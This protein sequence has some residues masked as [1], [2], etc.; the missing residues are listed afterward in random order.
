MECAVLVPRRGLRP[1]VGASRPR[2]SLR[3]P[4][5]IGQTRLIGIRFYPVAR[6]G[7]ADD[8]LLPPYAPSH[9]QLNSQASARLISIPGPEHHEIDP[10][11][12]SSDKARLA[13]ALVSWL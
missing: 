2:G 5:A 10:T 3:E 11:A 9:L 12:A 4:A 8:S 1:L 7:L 13:Y 6:R